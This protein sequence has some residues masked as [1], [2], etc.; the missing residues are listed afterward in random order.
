V[1][2]IKYA[3]EGGNVGVESPLRYLQTHAEAF[4]A[5]CLGILIGSGKD[6]LDIPSGRTLQG[7]NTHVIFKV[8]GVCRAGV[9]GISH[10]CQCQGTPGG[11][12]QYPDRAEF[13][14]GS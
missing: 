11:K 14:G 9:E 1:F 13:P 3:G 2:G 8:D 4:S 5:P 6:G 7:Y 12:A 10:A